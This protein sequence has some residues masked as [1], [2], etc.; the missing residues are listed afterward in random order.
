MYLFIYQSYILYCNLHLHMLLTC[1]IN[2][3][4][5]TLIQSSSF[6]VNSGQIISCHFNV[7][8]NITLFQPQCVQ[9]SGLVKNEIASQCQAKKMIHRNGI[10]I[11]HS[12]KCPQRVHFSWFRVA[13]SQL[14]TF[15]AKFSGSDSSGGGCCRELIPSK[16]ITEWRRRSSI[17]GL[18]QSEAAMTTTMMMMMRSARVH[19]L[20]V[21][22]TSHRR[23][24]KQCEWQQQI[25]LSAAFVSFLATQLRGD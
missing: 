3:F 25:P 6:F 10:E 24:R 13:V 7:T 8:K 4:W 17:K 9:Q 1:Q 22:R 18:W 15:C 16:Y 2:H 14:V 23:C 11:S 20:P 19:F 5:K 12:D 21:P